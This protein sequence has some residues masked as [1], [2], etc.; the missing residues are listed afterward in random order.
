MY[1]SILVQV[2]ADDANCAGRI[3]LAGQLA[4]ECG[5]MLLGVAAALPEPT[6]ELLASAGAAIAGGVLVSEHDDIYRSGS[7]RRGRNSPA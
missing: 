7:T 1:K 6:I 5:A 2:D 4:G 3:Q